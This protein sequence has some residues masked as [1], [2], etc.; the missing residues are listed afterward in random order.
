MEKGRQHYDGLPVR[1]SAI[2][3]ALLAQVAYKVIL[4]NGFSP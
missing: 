2:L 3:F 4:P 1:L